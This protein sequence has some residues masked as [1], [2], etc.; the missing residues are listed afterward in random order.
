MNTEQIVF[1]EN[2]ASLD[3]IYAHLLAC[4]EY[5]KPH[6]SKTVDIREY[7]K[8]IHSHAVT[9]EAWSDRRLIGLVVAYLNDT[10]GRH[11]YITNVSVVKEFMGRGIAKKLMAMCFDRSKDANFIDIMLEVVRENVEAIHLYQKCGFYPYKIAN[12]HVFMRRGFSP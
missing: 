2:K 1:T 4:N 5:Y 7:A 3:E 10:S 11:G 6:L 8:K 12:D 9:F